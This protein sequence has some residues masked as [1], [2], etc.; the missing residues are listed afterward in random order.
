[1]RIF[2]KDGRLDH[3]KQYR[4]EWKYVCDSQLLAVTEDRL[5][6]VLRRDSHNENDDW[7]YEI[8]SL[9]FD[10]LTNSC[11]KENDA[12]TAKRFKYRI[13]YY[14]S[15]S[16]RLRLERKEKLYGR[17][18]KES[19]HLSA[20]QYTKLI[21]GRAAEV[22]WETEDPLLK[23]FCIHCML[24][25]FRPKAIINY[26]RNAFVDPI[27]NVRVTL[28]ENISVSDEIPAFLTGAYHRIPVQEV[29]MHVLEVKFDAILPSYVRTLTSNRR[30]VQT[31]FSKYYLGRKKL[32]EV[33]RR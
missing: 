1:M 30:L 12:G 8:H 33:G 26:R 27:T 32:L 13:R 24:R 5:K 21:S 23:R 16:D 28:D 18:H 9:Y 17:C 2:T 19:C 11:A 31:A 7:G 22:L 20:E 29:N 10:D 15:Q 6:A 3:A 14:G 25:E 4:N